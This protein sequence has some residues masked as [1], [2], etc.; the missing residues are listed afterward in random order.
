MKPETPPMVKRMMKL[1]KNMK[2][3]VKI[4]RPNQ[5]VASQANTPT[6]DGSAMMMEAALKKLSDTPGNPVANM[7]CTQTPKPST[8]V[9]TVANATTLY[10]TSGRRQNTS[11]P[12]DTITIAGSTMA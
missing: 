9:A 5:I 8:M 12:S 2:A 4:G 11:K 10:P 1:A 6:A 3:V 7:W